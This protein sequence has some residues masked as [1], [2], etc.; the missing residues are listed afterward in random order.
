LL[1]QEKLKEAK[2]K[3]EELETKLNQLA[4]SYQN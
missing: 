1:A 3:A 2:E 4:F